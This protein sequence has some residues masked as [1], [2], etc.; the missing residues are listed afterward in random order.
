MDVFLSTA[1]KRNVLIYFN[2]RLINIEEKDDKVIIYFLDSISNI[3]DFSLA[4][5][6]FTLLSVS[7]TWTLTIYY[8]I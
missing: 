5:I 1:S 6:V 8:S 7:Y 4:V 3:G 2:K